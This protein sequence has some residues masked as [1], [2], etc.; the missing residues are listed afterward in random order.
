MTPDEFSP[1]FQGMVATFPNWRPT[2]GLS[3]TDVAAAYYNHLKKYR[4]KTYL[5]AVDQCCQGRDMMPSATVLAECCNQII[6]AM[7]PGE[8]KTKMKDL[9]PHPHTCS[10][11]IEQAERILLTAGDINHT[12][13]V[14]ITEATATLNVFSGYEA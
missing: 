6:A 9:V 13:S 7:P 1:T 8:R 14:A 3:V 5:R 11:R 12:F 4:I 2:N 10:P